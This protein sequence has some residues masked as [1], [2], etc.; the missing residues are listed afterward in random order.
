MDDL[1]VHEFNN[2][3]TMIG[4]NLELARPDSTG[5]VREA[6][7]RALDALQL[8]AIA[9]R[10]YQV[11]AGPAES[12]KASALH[13]AEEVSQAVELL[14][15]TSGSAIELSLEADLWPVRIPAGDMETVVFALARDAF[16]EL[17]SQGRLS[18]AVSNVRD[19]GGL[20]ALADAV[21]IDVRVAG[22]TTELRDGAKGASSSASHSRQRGAG[23]GLKVVRGLVERAGG[24]VEIT[25]ETGAGRTVS[26][27][28]PRAVESAA[29]QG[30][31]EQLPLGDGEL[32]LI[33]APDEKAGDRLARLV[34][35]LGYAA[36]VAGEQRA[37]EGSDA[38]C[39]PP[40]IVLWAGDETPPTAAAQSGMGAVK[41]R[42]SPEV[43][44]GELAEA[45]AK[46]IA[47]S[48]ATTG[49]GPRP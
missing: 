35:G 43:S 25:S 49:D 36:I 18:I 24:R 12:G 26:L 27:L 2:V 19:G 21:R 42:L 15:R 31:A 38:G 11:L 1:M 14:R 20:D 34:E 48:G 4:A 23:I 40:A 47:H 32:V 16:D 17:P 8:G 28:L 46:A 10:K 33:V 44:R 9:L 30:S 13:L 22:T 37:A 41:V 6:I 7:D 29:A 39:L 45:L 5:R 3:L